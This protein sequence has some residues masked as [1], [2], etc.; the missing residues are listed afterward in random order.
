MSTEEGDHSGTPGVVDFFSN[1]VS[2]LVYTVRCDD[3]SV[4]D[5]TTLK[6]PDLVRSPQLSRVGPGEY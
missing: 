2:V 5:H 6:A 4:Y 3:M 1:L